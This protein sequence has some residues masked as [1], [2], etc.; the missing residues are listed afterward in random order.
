MTEVICW[1]LGLIE[2][3]YFFNPLQCYSHY[4]NEIDKCSKFGTFK[5]LCGPIWSFSQ[6]LYFWSTCCSSL[7]IVT[8]QNQNEPEPNRMKITET[9]RLAINEFTPITSIH[10]KFPGY[11]VLGQV[12]SFKKIKIQF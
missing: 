9:N 12:Q 2:R 5:L 4:P 10:P 8:S 11:K 6:L 7:T 1:V 3:L